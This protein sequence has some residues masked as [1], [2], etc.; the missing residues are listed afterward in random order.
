[1]R[2][3]LVTVGTIITTGCQ[4][5]KCVSRIYSYS[6]NHQSAIC[7]STEK[8]IKIMNPLHLIVTLAALVLTQ[9]ASGFIVIESDYP[10]YDGYPQP[11]LPSRYPAPRPQSQEIR[12]KRKYKRED[13]Q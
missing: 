3:R 5:V 11:Q 8:N 12:F 13:I 10:K 1:M 2:G 6:I 4:D 9:I 7:Y